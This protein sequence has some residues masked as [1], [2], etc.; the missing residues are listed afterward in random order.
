[1]EMV[2][3]A[4]SQHRKLL[5]F[6]SN[7]VDG[8]FYFLRSLLAVGLLPLRIWAPS[9]QTFLPKPCRSWACGGLHPARMPPH[10]LHSVCEPALPDFNH[11]VAVCETIEKLYPAVCH[12]KLFLTCPNC[13]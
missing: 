3:T 13:A 1:M 5:W 7:V 4:S 12:Y 8:P 9:P 6:S 2:K 11:P 10:P